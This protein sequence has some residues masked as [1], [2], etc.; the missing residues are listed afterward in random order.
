LATK[1][2]LA[3]CPCHSVE[4]VRRTVDADHDGLGPSPIYHPER[5]RNV[6]VPVSRVT[7]PRSQAT[8]AKVPYRW[9]DWRDSRR[10]GCHA[11]TT[12]VF[13]SRAAQCDVAL[14]VGTSEVIL[15]AAVDRMAAALA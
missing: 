8:E 14:N 11:P 13:D 12:N 4:T 15:D 10:V 3:G 5:L 2:S 6:T 7:T 1:P 9:A